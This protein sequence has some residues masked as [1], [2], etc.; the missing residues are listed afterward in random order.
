MELT[1]RGLEEALK[2]AIG[3]EIKYFAVLIEIDGFPE[4][5]LIINRT[6]NFED[7]LQYYKQAYKQ[8]LNHKLQDHIRISGYMMGNTLNGLSDLF[9]K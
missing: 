2:T 3:N 5:E 1:M 7:K 4:N 9:N 6:A 8:N